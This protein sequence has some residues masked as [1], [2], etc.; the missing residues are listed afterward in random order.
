MTN[1]AASPCPRCGKAATGKF[2]AHCGA[3]L[4]PVACTACGGAVSPGSKFCNNCGAPAGEETRTGAGA[5]HPAMWIVPSIA[6]LAVIAYFV[7]QQYASNGDASANST[8]LGSSNAMAPFSGG[9]GGAAPTDISQ[10]SPEERA[11]RLFDRVMRYGEQGQLDSARIFAP[12]A[13]QAYEM[14]GTMTPHIRYD[15]GMIAVVAGDPA[16]A[17]AQADTILKADRTHLLGLLL[18][19]KAAAMRNDA[20]A[21]IA[22]EKRFL[23]AAPAEL[24]KK[25]PEY[26]DHKSDIDAALAASKAGT[27]K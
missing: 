19:T 2:C 11:S 27:L 5:R 24:A 1:P 13:T 26:D 9:G 16:V 12:M 14:L 4:Q 22:F 23:A 21:R 10:M 3:T 18:A 25:L 20:T 7:G 17:T 6:I 15:I 8:P